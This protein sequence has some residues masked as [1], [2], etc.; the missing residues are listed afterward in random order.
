MEVCKS[1][2]GTILYKIGCPVEYV[3]ARPLRDWEGMINLSVSEGPS[4][5]S[6]IILSRE[7]YLVR[8]CYTC[9]VSQYKMIVWWKYLKPL[10]SCSGSHAINIFSCLGRFFEQPTAPASLLEIFHSRQIL[11]ILTSWNKFQLCL[12]VIF[13]MRGMQPRYLIKEA[14]PTVHRGYSYFEIWSG[15][16]CPTGDTSHRRRLALRDSGS[17]SFESSL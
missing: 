12:K 11:A 4:L 14:Q 7:E 2:S 10:C 5:T 6:P 13:C 1:L 8:P 3:N 15:F 9:F 17:F 16:N